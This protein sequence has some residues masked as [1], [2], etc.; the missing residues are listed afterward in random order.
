MF[1]SW[2][3]ISGSLASRLNGFRH[4]RTKLTVLSAALFGAILLLISMAVYLAISNAAQHQVRSELIASGTVFDRVWSLRSD[5]LRQG[6]ALLSR[7]FGFR[8]A[9]AT[10]DQATI[11]SAMDNLRSRFRI[12]LAFIVGVDGTITASE[13]GRISPHA[14]TLLTA[15]S[16]SSD[17]AGVFALDGLPYQMVAVPILSPDLVG[18]V[19]FASRLDANELSALERLAAIP[20]HAS[21][22]QPSGNT[23]VTS[24]SMGLGDHRELN[25]FVESALAAK[26]RGPRTLKSRAGA[27][28]ALIKPLPSLATSDGAALLLTYPLAK[29]LAPYRPLP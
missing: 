27:A 17:P 29:A 26:V 12:D 20:L 25:R 13:T 23:W 5:Q 1:L 2:S 11:I 24:D 28:I 18:W 10:G 8:A 22:V 4:L 7:D 14:Q 21:V 19:V 16:A 9:V 3:H 6:A 15:L